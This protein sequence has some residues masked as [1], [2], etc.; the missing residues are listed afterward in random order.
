MF[1]DITQ[2][3]V[4]VV[5]DRAGVQIGGRAPPWSAAV[6]PVLEVGV[7][8]GVQ[9]T[10]ADPRASLL[11]H[12]VRVLAGAR[13]MAYLMEN[14]YGLAY[15][16]QNG[17]VFER[18]QHSVREAG[19]SLSWRVLLAADYGVPQ[20]R[21]RLVCV[22]IRSD[23]LD[24]PIDLWNFDCPSRR[25]AGRMRRGRAGTRR[26]RVDASMCGEAGPLRAIEATSPLIRVA[27][28]ARGVQQAHVAK[29]ASTQ[30]S[31]WREVRRLGT[32]PGGCAV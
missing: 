32:V 28:D 17:A 26:H 31:L 16:N 1:D 9:A 25:T 2:L 4:D 8:V 29:P 21:Q 5:L 3:D 22:G 24:V 27:D 7:L 15:R 10:R 12:Y 18:F 14:V 6:Y 13:P 19:Y 20:L 30:R 23:V 11:D